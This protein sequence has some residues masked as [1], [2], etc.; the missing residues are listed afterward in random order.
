M[1]F[2]ELLEQCD[3][4]VLGCFVFNKT[5]FEHFNLPFHNAALRTCILQVEIKR[6]F[7]L[8]RHP[9]LNPA[10]CSAAE[11]W[12]HPASI[13]TSF[14]F[15]KRRSLFL[16]RKPGRKRNHSGCHHRSTEISQQGR[17]LRWEINLVNQMIH[18]TTL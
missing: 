18:R 11:Y 3:K 15:R 7:F 8:R 17:N 1:N 16:S 9:I 5:N 10:P 4:M 14:R 6:T 2:R 12:K 13:L